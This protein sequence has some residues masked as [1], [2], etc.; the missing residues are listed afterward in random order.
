M[1]IKSTYW[2]LNCTSSLHLRSLWGDDLGSLLFGS[3]IAMEDVDVEVSMS[4]GGQQKKRKG[5]SNDYL[6]RVGSAQQSTILNEDTVL[7]PMPVAQPKLLPIG[8]VIDPQRSDL[9][10]SQ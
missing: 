6:I 7:P 4:S 5:R 2:L 9:T 10:P 8:T 3:P 1:E